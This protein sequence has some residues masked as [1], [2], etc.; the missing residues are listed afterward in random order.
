VRSPLPLYSHPAPGGRKLAPV[1]SRWCQ[2]AGLRMHYRVSAAPVPDGRIPVVLVHGFVISSRFMVTLLE[3]MGLEFPTAAPDLP[4]F[5][6]SEKP[7]EL[8]DVSAHAEVLMAW[9]DAVGYRRV[10]L[11]GNSLGCQIAA[12]CAMRHPDRIAGIVLQ[13]PTV[14]R[15][16]RTL[17]RQILRNLADSRRE[18]SA[19]IAPLVDYLQ[20]GLSRAAKMARAMIQH[21]IEGVLPHV[22]VPALVVRGSQDPVV[23][24][25][26]AE[27]VTEL[28]PRGRLVVVPGAA[29]AMVFSNALELTGVCQPFL[30]GLNREGDHR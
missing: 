15:H 30:V 25:Y 18:D 11:L 22:D 9:I 19:G 2:A 4:G 27:E 10:A 28:L 5:G 23:P 20:A 7:R 26:W 8:L 29:H 12:E 6:R 1:Q 17:P 21:R 16:A 24:Q 13:G 3:R 14:D